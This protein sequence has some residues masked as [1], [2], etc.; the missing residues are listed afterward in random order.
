MRE[1]ED[2][3]E[4]EASLHGEK[5]NSDQKKMNVFHFFLSENYIYLIIKMFHMCVMQ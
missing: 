4:I 2:L 1:R 3:I 5:Q